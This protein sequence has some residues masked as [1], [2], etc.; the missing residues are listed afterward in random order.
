MPTITLTVGD[1]R[2][3]PPSIGTYIDSPPVAGSGLNHWILGAVRRLLHYVTENETLEE[4]L[5]KVVQAGRAYG[6]ARSEILRAIAKVTASGDQAIQE[7]ADWPEPNLEKI[8]AIVREELAKLGGK[9]PIDALRRE[10][11]VKR[12]TAGEIIDALF[13]GDPLLCVGIS[14]YDFIT[15][16]KST[17]RDFSNKQLI[18]PSPMSAVQGETQ[19]G[20]LSFKSDAN[21]GPR[22]FLALDFDITEFARDGVTPT[23]FAPLIR[24][25][26][27]DG[28]APKQAQAAIILYLKRRLDPVLALDS[29][30]K[31]LH[32]WFYVEGQTEEVIKATMQHAVRLGADRATYTRSQFVRMPGGLR[33]NGKRQEVIYFNPNAVNQQTKT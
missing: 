3:F 7:R 26:R 17:Y 11:P 6:K 16:R 8:A 14:V 10:S 33:D 21:T 24:T 20:K 32:A 31:S 30:G 25:W 28:I 29:G 9:C 18:V 12:A 15:R 2:P 13:P 19:E 23:V 5:P 22:R 1:Y 27:T 4:L